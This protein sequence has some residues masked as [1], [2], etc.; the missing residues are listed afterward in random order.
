MVA[1]ARV[2]PAQDARTYNE[3]VVVRYGTHETPGDGET[4]KTVSQGQRPGVPDA[5]TGV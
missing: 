1:G 2:W 5:R 4:P 3:H